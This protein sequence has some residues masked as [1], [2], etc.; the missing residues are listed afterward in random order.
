MTTQKKDITLSFQQEEEITSIFLLEDLIKEYNNQVIAM[1]F[2]RRKALLSLRDNDFN[3][4]NP[5]IRPMTQAEIESTSP[6]K[7]IPGQWFRIQK[8]LQEQYSLT[9]LVSNV[10]TIAAGATLLEVINDL[11]LNGKATYKTV[12]KKTYVI[13]KGL[14]KDRTILKGTRYL[15]T[16]PDIVRLGLAKVSI[17]DL[18][19]T[20][21]KNSFLIYSGIKTLEGLKVCLENGGLDSNFFSQVGTDIPKLAISTYT[22]AVLGT[23]VGSAVAAAGLPIV[24]G[25]GIVIVLGVSVGI[26][27]ELIDKKIG[28]TEKLSEAVETMWINLRKSQNATTQNNKQLSMNLNL[29]EGLVFEAPICKLPRINQKGNLFVYTI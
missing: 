1:P 4:N 23:A 24:L 3:K 21:L 14:A 17:T 25:S 28:F 5:I 27:L 9:G 13:L 20:G 10:P 29:L 26:G 18:C 19:K 16:H 11:G 7:M 12:D 8:I 6:F 15:N 22:T 2:Y